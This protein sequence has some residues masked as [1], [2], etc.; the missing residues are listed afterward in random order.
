MG[1]APYPLDYS[2][3]ALDRGA[4]VKAYYLETYSDAKERF[5]AYKKDPYA[6]LYL[7]EAYKTLWDYFW[8]LAN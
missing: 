4:Q 2:L 5:E 8:G 6:A 3:S 7:C 1:G